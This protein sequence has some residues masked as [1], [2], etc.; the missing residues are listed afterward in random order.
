MKTNTKNK[1]KTVKVYI[2]NIQIL[3][4]VLN[5]SKYDGPKTINRNHFYFNVK[6]SNKISKKT[7][8]IYTLTTIDIHFKNKPKSKPIEICKII[9]EI[10]YRF[11]NILDIVKIKGKAIQLPEDLM[12]KMLNTSFNTTRGILF[13]KLSGTIFEKVYLP[14]IETKAPSS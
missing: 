9:V 10:E 11:E 6:G 5:T 12:H 1:Q 8:S 3:D 14:P 7:N 13:T 2:N 4:F